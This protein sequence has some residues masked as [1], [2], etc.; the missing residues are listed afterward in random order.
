MEENNG[1]MGRDSRRQW[2]VG[3]SHLRRQLDGV[4]KEKDKIKTE[5]DE[6]AVLVSSEFAGNEEQQAVAATNDMHMHALTNK[7]ERQT[8]QMHMHVEID[9]CIKTSHLVNKFY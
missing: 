6:R 3:D 7:E 8:G 2:S 4:K 5:I 1:N 9:A